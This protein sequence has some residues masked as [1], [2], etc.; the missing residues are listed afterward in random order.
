MAWQQFGRTCP[1][2]GSLT[3]SSLGSSS[4]LGLSFLVF[5]G[6]FMGF[7]DSVITPSISM[8]TSMLIW[9]YFSASCCTT[10]FT[11]EVAAF[12]MPFCIPHST[13]RCTDSVM[14]NWIDDILMVG[15]L[16][17]CLLVACCLIVLWITWRKI[18]SIFLPR[19]TG[20]LVR[21]QKKYVHLVV[22]SLIVLWAKVFHYFTHNKK[23]PRSGTFSSFIVL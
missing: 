22:R 17:A 14:L 20:S 12:S 9:S 16:I 11:S 1:H 19:H 13:L 18:K 2:H 15:L 8:A 23:R 4:D 6:F 10:S 21:T 3:T 5:L 7:L